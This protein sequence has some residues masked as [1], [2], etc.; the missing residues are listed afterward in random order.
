MCD[1]RE[2]AVQVSAMPTWLVALVAERSVS[3]V[4]N[5]GTV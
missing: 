1:S 5:V 4:Q 3:H 2:I